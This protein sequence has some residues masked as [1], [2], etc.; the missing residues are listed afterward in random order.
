[1]SQGSSSSDIHP[2]PSRVS[3]PR[4]ANQNPAPKTTR[5]LS[6]SKPIGLVFSR[7]R[8]AELFS[9]LFYVAASRL[10][11]PRVLS[12]GIETFS[13][14]PVKGYNRRINGRLALKFLLTYIV[15]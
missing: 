14:L 4:G 5:G 11:S 7:E 12:T 3:L 8:L 15:R 10:N 13:E 6:I 1:M 9:C 2:L